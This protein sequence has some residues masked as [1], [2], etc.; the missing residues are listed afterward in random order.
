MTDVEK[1]ASQRWEMLLKL[2]LHVQRIGMEV[3]TKTPWM[4]TVAVGTSGVINIC[5]FTIKLFVILASYESIVVDNSM[6]R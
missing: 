4:A 3:C 2:L 6:I 1:D 5:H